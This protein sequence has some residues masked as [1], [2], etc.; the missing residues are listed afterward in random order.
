[1][2]KARKYWQLLFIP[3][4]IL[5]VAGL[6]AGLVSGWLPLHIGLVVAGGVILVFWLGLLLSAS[7]G[8][9]GRRS[10]QAGTNALVATGAV[11]PDSRTN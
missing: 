11:I 4:L 2:T 3:G 8:F 6:V 7:R 9:W 5:L 1:M 10:T